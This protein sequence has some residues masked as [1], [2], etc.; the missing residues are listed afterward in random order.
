MSEAL[1]CKAISDHSVLSF[2][3]KG[4]SRTVEPHALGYNQKNTLVLSAWQLSGGSGQGFRD[5]I[6]AEITAVSISP[7][8]FPKPRPGYN[9]QD[10][11][12]KKIL[13][14]L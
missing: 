8:T 6:M 7:Q 9:P 10:S 1:M 14:R 3:Y 5:F 12:M 11:T 2:V 13:C 4:S